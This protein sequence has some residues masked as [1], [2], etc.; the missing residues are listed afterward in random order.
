MQHEMEL[1]EKYD[2]GWEEWIC[3]ECGRHFFAKWNPFK[4]DIIEKGNE[5]VTHSGSYSANYGISVTRFDAERSSGLSREL[6]KALE[7]LD[8]DG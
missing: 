7:E 6:E 2:D 3:P 5:E 4:R 8:F 1:L